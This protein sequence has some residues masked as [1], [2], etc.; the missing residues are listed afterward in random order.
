[1]THEEPYQPNE[2]LRR[3]QDEH[4]SRLERGER[5]LAAAGAQ[6]HESLTQARKGLEP[7]NQAVRIG[8]RRRTRQDAIQVAIL[9]LTA[10]SVVTAIIVA[11]S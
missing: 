8:L 2:A 6:A 7:C 3:A 4:N 5:I 10:I 9:V 1:V 11:V